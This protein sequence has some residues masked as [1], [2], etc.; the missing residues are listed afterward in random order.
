MY[1]PVSIAYLPARIALDCLRLPL[2]ISL[3]GKLVRQLNL[4]PPLMLKHC[5]C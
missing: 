2:T 4:R 3:I 5:Y 1:L